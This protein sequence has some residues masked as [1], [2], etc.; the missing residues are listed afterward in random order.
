[1]G[2]LG[3]IRRR[4]RVRKQGRALFMGLIAVGWGGGDHSVVFDVG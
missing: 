4:I 3:V 2:Y 1:V